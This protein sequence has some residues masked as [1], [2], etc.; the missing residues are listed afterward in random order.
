MPGGNDHRH[1]AVQGRVITGGGLGGA[2]RQHQADRSIGRL[3]RLGQRERSGDRHRLIRPA[4]GHGRLIYGQVDNLVV[5]VIA[6]GDGDIQITGGDGETGRGGNR[7]YQHRFISLNV[8]IRRNGDEH[9]RGSQ[10]PTG[11][12]SQDHIA[13]QSRVVAVGGL[14]GTVR[15]C[16]DD[17]SS[18]RFSPLGLRER[19]GDRHRLIRRPLYYGRLINGQIDGLGIVIGQGYG[20]LAR[21]GGEPGRG[22]DRPQD[23]RLIPLG[24]DIIRNGDRDIGGSG[25]LTGCNFQVNIARRGPVVAVGG[26]SGA[27]HHPQRKRSIGGLGPRERGGNPHRLIRRPLRYGRLV[28][29][30]VDHLVVVVDN[31]YTEKMAGENCEPVRK[32]GSRQSNLRIRL[33][34][35]VLGHRDGHISGTR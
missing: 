26:F 2:V 1:S 31:S 25:S 6:I 33:G 8:R 13:R 18:G 12:N 24:R 3:G 28:N 35:A 29:R 7:P 23:N 20:Y 10:R 15:Q 19:G 9:V 34:V 27:V 30:Q 11:G 14:R 17:R 21:G 5:I 22:G 4:F 32:V 16:Q